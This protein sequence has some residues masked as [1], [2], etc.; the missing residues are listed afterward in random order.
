MDIVDIVGVARS[1]GPPP[2]GRVSG[3]CMAPWRT[4]M[5]LGF[6]DSSGDTPVTVLLRMTQLYHATHYGRDSGSVRGVLSPLVVE[7]TRHAAGTTEE[8][9]SASLYLGQTSNF[10]RGLWGGVTI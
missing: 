7:R 10:F 2:S 1:V 9:N 4:G 6:Q 8:S 5:R 3:D